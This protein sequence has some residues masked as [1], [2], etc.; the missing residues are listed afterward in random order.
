MWIEPV[1]ELLELVNPSLMP[2]FCIRCLHA[3]IYYRIH[4]FKDSKAKASG[5]RVDS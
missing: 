3:P 2:V 5:S 1:Y 4:A